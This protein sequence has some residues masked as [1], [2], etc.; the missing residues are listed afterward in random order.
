MKALKSTSVQTLM[1]GSIL[2]SG[3]YFFTDEVSLPTIFA[4][5]FVAIATGRQIRNGIQAN[6]GQYFDGEKLKTV[7]NDI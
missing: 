2:C 1:I 7:N 6:K 4:G 5:G 3:M